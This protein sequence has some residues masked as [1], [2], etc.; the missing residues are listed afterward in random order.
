MPA[1]AKAKPRSFAD[2]LRQRS[3]EEIEALLASRPDL[4]DAH[5]S[6]LGRLAAVAVD[7]LSVS[8]A[9]DDLDPRQLSLIELFAALPDP[10][11]RQAAAQAAQADISADIDE[12]WSRGLLWGTDEL[13]LVRFARDSFGAYPCRLAPSLVERKPFLSAW[14]QDPASVQAAVQALPDSAQQ[15]LRQLSYEGPTLDYA[16]AMTSFDEQKPADD[17]QLLI[18]Q[19][20]LIATDPTT[21]LVPR[22]VALRVREGQ[23]L[24]SRLP[25]SE[26]IFIDISQSDDAAAANAYGATRGMVSIVEAMAGRA[27]RINR[28]R[29]LVR[30]DIDS[31]ADAARRT[32][33]VT[34]SLLSVG[35]VAG[36]V[37]IDPAEPDLLELTPSG[38][39][40]K[41][42]PL[43][44]QWL[45]LARSWVNCAGIA[46]LITSTGVIT[47]DRIPRRQ[48]QSAHVLVHAAISELSAAPAGSTAA[49]LHDADWLQQLRPRLEPTTADN[50]RAWLDVAEQLG[51]TFRGVVSSFGRA[52][53]AG[54]DDLALAHLSAALSPEVESIYVQPD[55]T[56]VVPGRPSRSLI[57]MLT[58][59]ADIENEDS[60]LLV[61]V[62]PTS[63]NRALY[64]GL[65][66]SE[67]L[68]FLNNTS[69]SPIGQ[70]LVYML[71]DQERRF[72]SLKVITAQTILVAEDDAAATRILQDSR[73]SGLRLRCIN[74]SVL[75]CD[76]DLP[77]VVEALRSSGHSPLVDGVQAP[78]TQRLSGHTAGVRLVET[79]PHIAGRVHALAAALT[80]DL[81]SQA[82][83]DSQEAI[84][85][86]R[87]NLTFAQ[88]IARAHE[89]QHDI[90]LVY[91]DKA[92][93]LQRVQA[94][95][96]HVADGFVTFYSRATG[97]VS[98]ISMARISSIH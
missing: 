31:L 48:L 15:L 2:D 94:R 85:E 82:A 88:Q 53:A 8:R 54:S 91:A 32:S 21:V 13:H 96:V 18:S 34:Q 28:S 77:T 44:Q 1:A 25:S 41:E 23:W 87:G 65:N 95:V 16:G 45:Q 90:S 76:A 30:A 11:T 47:P 49:Q 73:L 51:L 71:E 9:L 36:I 43:E 80:G 17:V 64:A 59:F 57:T 78:A 52:V 27:L 38:L 98:T 93:D 19:R 20:L 74:P 84:D 68:E 39:A 14:L 10:F 7:A 58:T 4:L 60:A 72:G 86:H 26:T 62:S 22:E 50:A 40:W 24:I 61:R 3:T 70:A 42:L 97:D 6:D 46:A 75:C 67:I 5:V 63:I 89:G 55:N 66:S 79:P 83:E 37:G 69:K 29:S 81:Q 92:G 35:I 33:A 56:I 12:F